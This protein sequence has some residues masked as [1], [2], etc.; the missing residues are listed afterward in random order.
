MFSNRW[1]PMVIP[2]MA[3]MFVL[4]FRSIFSLM[5]WAV[6][7]TGRVSTTFRNMLTWAGVMMPILF[8]AA[9]FGANWVAG[10]WCIGFPIVFLIS[11][12]RIAR[13]LQ[14]TLWLL[15]RPMR[16]PLLC[17]L[18]SSVVVAVVLAP[19]GTFFPFA[20]QLAFGVVLGGVC[21]GLLMRRYARQD[22][23]NARYLATRLLRR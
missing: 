4:P 12:E 13:A 5:D 20:A 19:G 18:A 11:M 14:V 22:F 7:G 1:A 15:L 16:A 6:I 2:F 23:D 10:S 21:Y 17:S 3:F 9:H 8:V